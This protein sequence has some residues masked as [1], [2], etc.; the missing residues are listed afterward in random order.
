MSFS[1]EIDRMLFVNSDIK[2]EKFNFV[3]LYFC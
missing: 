2:S 3:V 1:F